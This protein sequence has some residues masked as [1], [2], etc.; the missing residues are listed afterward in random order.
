MSQ[1]AIGQPVSFVPT[2]PYIDKLIEV[3]GVPKDGE[4]IETNVIEATISISRK[5]SHWGT[6]IA[7]YKEILRVNY[8]VIL[9]CKRG[10]GYYHACTDDEKIDEAMCR[11]SRAEREVGRT[12]M[13]L[14]TVDRTKL[15]D[16]NKQLY[17]NVR[18]NMQRQKLLLAQ[19]V[20]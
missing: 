6:I 1:A 2:K 17:D 13:I 5:S 15:S 4:D 19:S 3:I 12:M 20:K 18:L 10:Q 14:D 9:V 16:I 7:R 8:G 11:K